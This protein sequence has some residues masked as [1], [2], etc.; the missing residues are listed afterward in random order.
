MANL[1]DIDP[2][3]RLIAFLSLL[4]QLGVTAEVAEACLRDRDEA[5]CRVGAFMAPVTQAQIK[6]WRTIEIGHHKNAEAMIAALESAGYKLSKWAR[7]ILAKTTFAQEVQTL[8]L[9]IATNKELGYPN[10]ATREQAYEAG[11]KRDWQLCPAELGPALREQYKDQLMDEW[12]LI[13][14][15]PIMDSDGVLSVFS[16]GRGSDGSWLSTCYDFPGYRWNA[17]G[18]WV[19]VC[20]KQ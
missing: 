3:G 16:V 10:G 7:D 8:E 2:G 9:V 14:M 5:K 12:L 11:L 19:F 6:P 1:F 17:R 18:R 15:E 13:A 4:N 20:S